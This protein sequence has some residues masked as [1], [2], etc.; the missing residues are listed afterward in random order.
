MRGVNEEGEVGSEVQ[1]L[2]EGVIVITVDA[3]RRIYDPG[4]VAIQ[5]GRIVRTGNATAC[6]CT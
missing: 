4:Y 3:G 5:G 6:P 1:R 2:I